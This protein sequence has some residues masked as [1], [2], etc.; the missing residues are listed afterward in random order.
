[1][2]CHVAVI[3]SLHLQWSSSNYSP[4]ILGN[5]GRDWWLM[6]ARCGLSSGYI[7]NFLMSFGVTLN[8]QATKNVTLSRIAML[9]I[10]FRALLSVVASCSILRILTSNNWL[11][12]EKHDFNLVDS[13]AFSDQ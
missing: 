6:C 10:M 8:S 7:N 12:A 3:F 2:I 13:F 9:Y 4:E 1:M 5:G 11:R